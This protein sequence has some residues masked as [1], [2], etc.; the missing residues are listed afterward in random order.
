DQRTGERHGKRHVVDGEH[1]HHRC[2]GED[3]GEFAVAFVHDAA[4]YWHWQT[5]TSPLRGGRKLPGQ[6]RLGFWGGAR[7]FGASPPTC[8]AFGR[9]TFDLP[10]RRRLTSR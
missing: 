3:G 10:S 6:S 7:R 9:P 4:S 2:G 1:R 5:P 8:S